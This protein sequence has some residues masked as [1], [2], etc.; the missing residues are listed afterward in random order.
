LDPRTCAAF[1]IVLLELLTGKVPAQVAALHIEEPD[2]F[3]EMHQYV[4]ARAGV[5]AWPPGVVGR[6]AGI[7]ER[8]IAYHPRR[9]AA[10]R[11]VVDELEELAQAAQL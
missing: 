9:R 5:G 7:A 8:C 3:A 11:G 6:L 4:D 1:A 10:V 2:L